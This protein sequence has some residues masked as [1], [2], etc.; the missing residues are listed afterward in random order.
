MMKSN[1]YNTMTDGFKSVRHE[2]TP[3]KSQST[4]NPISNPIYQSVNSDDNGMVNILSKN[5]STKQTAQDRI[6]TL[7][8]NVENLNASL[9]KIEALSSK[10]LENMA[11]TPSNTNVVPAS[12]STPLYYETG[13]VQATNIEKG[14]E[15]KHGMFDVLKPIIKDVSVSAPHVKKDGSKGKSFILNFPRI[16]ENHPLVDKTSSQAQQ[17]L[18]G[19]ALWKA[20]A[21]SGFTFTGAYFNKDEGKRV[22]TT[23]I[24][25]GNEQPVLD[26]LKKQGV[27][28]P[29]RD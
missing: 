25:A 29:K 19:K 26:W 22:F 28:I 14:E 27:H 1:K 2:I 9:G 11:S 3:L 7:E 4:K 17:K 8:A 13:R 18:Q 16:D 5:M 20:V 21:F 15:Q 6:S 23:Y 10:I 12:Q 24:K